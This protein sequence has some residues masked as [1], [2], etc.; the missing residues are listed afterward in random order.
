[1][2]KQRF[3]EEQIAG[4]LRDAEA[5]TI[6]QAARQ[7][8]V[9][10]QSIY[11]WKRQFGA[12]EVANVRELRQLRQEN[13]RLKKVLAERD[14]EVEVMKELQT[15]KVVSPRTRRQM[16]HTACARGLRMRRAAWLYSTPRSG[17]GYTSRILR[18]DAR[19]A[20]ALRGVSERYPQWGYQLAG[21]FLQGR[22]WPVNLKRIHR[23]WRQQGL[24]LP[25]RKRRRQFRTGGTILLKAK[26]AHDVWSWD[27]VH[28]SYG[29]GEPFR[30]LTVKDEAT[31]FCLAIAVGRS[32]TQRHVIEVLRQ[33]IARHGRPRYLR[34]DNGP[35]LVAN[36][37]T[38]FLNDLEIIPSRIEP[39]KPWQNGS[40]ESFNGTFCR[41]CLDAELFQSLAEA[42]VVI[43]GW[44]RLYN[45]ER[46]H[47]ALG[48][49]VPSTVFERAITRK[50]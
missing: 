34:S 14:L 38:A 29:H 4:I 8:G 46:P 42:R 49:R 25:S 24:G 37:L 10:V 17:L 23:L 40:N 48:Y 16:A 39:G 30:C 27:F 50:T 6:E 33:L 32:L 15:K 1:M 7:H 9:S 2:K 21:S 13:V 36:K 43:E 31:R 28:D 5:G 26:T 47:S 3:M 18:R 35:E 11:R 44:R 19:L 22:G 20:Q 45:Y 12:M 41:E